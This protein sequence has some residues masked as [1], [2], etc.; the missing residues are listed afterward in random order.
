[1]SSAR[2]TGSDPML[3]ND[4]VDKYTQGSPVVPR[5]SNYHVTVE[6]TFPLEICI[7]RAILYSNGRIS[8]CRLLKS[9]G[10]PSFEIM[11][12][13]GCKAEDFLWFGYL[14]T[15]DCCAEIKYSKAHMAHGTW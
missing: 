8:P 12:H 3:D 9:S 7:L 13:L 5:L 11:I 6:V 15:V 4:P 10:F 2:L 1:M 14:T